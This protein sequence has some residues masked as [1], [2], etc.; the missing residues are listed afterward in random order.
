MKR[1]VRITILKS[2]MDQKLAEEYAVSGYNGI[3]I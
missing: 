3:V 1:D 2:E